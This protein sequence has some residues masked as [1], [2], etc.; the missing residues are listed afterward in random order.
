MIFLVAG[1]LGTFSEMLHWRTSGYTDLVP[2]QGLRVV[3]PSL[4]AIL[5][6]TQ[7]VFSS[8]FM[9]LLRMNSKY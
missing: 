5:V 1:F 2:E 3:I 8:F 7:M 4:T 9:A 6:G